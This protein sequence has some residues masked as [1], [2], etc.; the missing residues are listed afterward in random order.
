[1]GILQKILET[2]NTAIDSIDF[3]PYQLISNKSTSATLTENSDTLYPSQKAVKTYVDTGLSGKQDSLGYTAENV[4]NKNVA[5]GYEGLNDIGRQDSIFTKIPKTRYGWFFNYLIAALNTSI[6]SGNGTGGGAYYSGGVSVTPKLK[7]GTID[8]WNIPCLYLGASATGYCHMFS[9]QTS[10]KITTNCTVENEW[11]VAFKFNGTAKQMKCVIALGSIGMNNNG[12]FS[13]NGLAFVYDPLV[14]SG[15]FII[16]KVV[17]GSVTASANTSTAPIMETTTKFRVKYS[18]VNEI[19]EFF[20]NNVNAGS[21]ASVNLANTVVYQNN[22]AMSTSD[23]TETQ[24]RSM[25]A[26]YSAL[27]VDIG[28]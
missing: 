21:L 24:V 8:Y 19:A 14:N 2:I 15:N 4:A 9:G 18:K 7:G 10:I 1:M 3:S 22:L 25:C 26:L 23:S 28:E 6:I 17:N 12:I 20:I 5:N 27:E 13:G 11:A 16:V